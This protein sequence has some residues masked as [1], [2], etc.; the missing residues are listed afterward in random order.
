MTGTQTAGEAPLFGRPV[1]A[2]VMRHLC[3]QADMPM[4]AIYNGQGMRE[5]ALYRLQHVGGDLDHDTA[6]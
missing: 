2:E 6:E 3:A 4:P 5:S 1:D